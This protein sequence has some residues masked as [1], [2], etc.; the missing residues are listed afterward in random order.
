MRLNGCNLEPSPA[1]PQP[2]HSIETTVTPMDT[3]Y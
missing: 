1:H 2:E 3:D